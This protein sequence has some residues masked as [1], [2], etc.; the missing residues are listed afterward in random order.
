MRP[1]PA[2]QPHDR[3]A[4][5]PGES[6]GRTDPV[7]FDPGREGRDSRPLRQAAMRQ[8]SRLAF[9]EACLAGPAG[10]RPD[11]P[12]LAVAVAG[13]EVASVASAGERAISILAT[14]SREVV[15]GSESSRVV[16]GRDHRTQASHYF[17]V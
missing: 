4:M 8:R 5:H 15:P 17:E 10:E 11:R 2:R 3:V 12:V 6:F 7:A 14:E 16:A 9:G 13:R 1:G